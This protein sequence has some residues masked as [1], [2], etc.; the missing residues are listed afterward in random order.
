M[1]Q[2]FHL[3]IFRLISYNVCYVIVSVFVVGR[4]YSSKE[5]LSENKFPL[6]HKQSFLFGECVVRM[7][8]L[9][10]SE[11]TKSMQI[12]EIILRLSAKNSFLAHLRYKKQTK[13]HCCRKEQKKR[14]TRH[15]GVNVTINQEGQR[16]THQ[17]ARYYIIHTHAHVTRV[18]EQA[19]FCLTCD[20][21][22]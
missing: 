7:K 10:K 17:S 6:D 4:S 11:E 22:D 16:N 5:K 15:K 13:C 18:I 21:C 3:S 1:F 14:D 9:K 8:I 12:T 2:I 20:P 19:D